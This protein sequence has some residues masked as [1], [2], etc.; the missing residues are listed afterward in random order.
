MKLEREVRMEGNMAYVPY[1]RL[2]VMA[3]GVLVPMKV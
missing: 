1:S 2:K 3:I